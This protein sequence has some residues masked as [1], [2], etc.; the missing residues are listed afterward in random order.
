M[1]PRARGSSAENGGKAVLPKRLTSRH[2][3]ERDQGPIPLQTHDNLSSSTTMMN[4]EDIEDRDG[5]RTANF[6]EE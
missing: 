2:V 6:V 5:A 3:D 1:F 4:F